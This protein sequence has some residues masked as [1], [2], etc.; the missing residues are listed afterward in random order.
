MSEAGRFTEDAPI[1]CEQTTKDECHPKDIHG[2]FI[3]E[4]IPAMMEVIGT[5]VGD[6]QEGGSNA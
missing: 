2:Q 6:R 5:V 3:N 1:E 4:I